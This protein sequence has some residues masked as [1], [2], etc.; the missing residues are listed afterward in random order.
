M[1]GGLRVYLGLLKQWWWLLV[2]SVVIPAAISFQFA[3]RRPD[4]YQARA[5]LMVGASIQDPNPAQ[6]EI[7]LSTALANAYAELVVQAPVVESVIERLALQRTPAQLAAQIGTIVY[8]GAQLLEIQ[9]TDTNPEAAALI[10]NALAEEL[11][12]RSPTSERNDPAQQRFIESQMQELQGKIEGLAEQV[13]GLTAS[14]AEL[15]SAAEIQDTQDRISAFEEVKSLYQ[16]TYANLLA[17]SRSESPNVVSLFDPAVVPARPVPTRTGLVVAVAGAAGLG[18]AA[19]AILLME[20]LD[21]SIRWEGDG[22]RSIEDLPVLGAIPRVSR[23]DVLPASDPLGPVAEAVRSLRT[24]LYLLHP[25][26]SLGTLL[27]T[28]PSASEGKSFILANLAVVLASSGKRVIMVDADMRRPSLHEYFDRPNVSGLAEL[29]SCDVLDG[30]HVSSIQTDFDNVTLISAGKPPVD[31]AAL[32]TSPR[33]PSLLAALRNQADLILIDSPPILGPA[34]GVILATHAEGTILVVGVGLT[35]RD[36]VAQAKHRLLAQGG[37]GFLGVA[38]NRAKLDD[39]YYYYRPERERG[40]PRSD[41]EIDGEEWMSLGE[42]AGRLGIS[43]AM[44]RRWCRTGRLPAARAKLRTRV[45]SED[46]ERVRQGVP[47]AGS[48]E[49][50]SEDQQC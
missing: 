18:L 35:R 29:L 41:E 23:R 50:G 19:G 39:S 13:D 48:T 27:F 25:D 24:N 5:T 15:T 31:T 20:Y 3:S 30:G 1:N 43:R 37:R 38:V 28:S 47:R 33:L 44:A 6:R 40:K 12:L 22:V 8:S 32:L 17:V 4:L 16:S 14:L 26:E 10:A 34:D 46:V 11:V 49:T 2:L 7:N 45:R 42:A 21:A 9:V 36:S